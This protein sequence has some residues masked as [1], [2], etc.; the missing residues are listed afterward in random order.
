MELYRRT[1][2][3]YACTGWNNQNGRPDC[4]GDDGIIKKSQLIVDDRF[5]SSLRYV[6]E[7]VIR[8]ADYKTLSEVS[9]L[10]GLSPR[11]IR[12]YVE[13]NDNSFRNDSERKKD[14]CAVF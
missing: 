11:E 12:Y 4:Q 7:D 9:E 6:Y 10:T 5:R 8:M 1:C 14:I 3:Q 2:I 13:K